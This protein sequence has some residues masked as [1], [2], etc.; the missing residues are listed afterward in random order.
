MGLRLQAL[1]RG[2]AVHS[3]EGLPL[4]PVC[5]ACR[6]TTPGGL[7]ESALAAGLRDQPLEDVSNQLKARYMLYSPGGGMA[8]ELAKNPTVLLV[9]DILFAHGGVLPPHGELTE[10]GQALRCA[11][12]GCCAPL[13]VLC[14]AQLTSKWCV[15]LPAISVRALL[16]SGSACLPCCSV[17]C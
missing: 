12:D 8:R 3:S 4:L 15:H 11:F 7:R 6:Y 2:A 1:L 14:S 10:P 16:L 17:Q 9:N 13:L 5:T